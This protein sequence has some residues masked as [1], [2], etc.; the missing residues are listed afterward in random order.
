MKKKK[1]GK[2]F[3]GKKIKK[4]AQII[5]YAAYGDGLLQC[6]YSL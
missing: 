2:S 5:P 1:I 3:T 4:S 6:A